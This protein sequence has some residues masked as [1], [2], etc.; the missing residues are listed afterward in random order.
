MAPKKP[1]SGPWARRK[2]GL[3]KP[4]ILRGN[5]STGVDLCWHPLPICLWDPSVWAAGDGQQASASLF[6]VR[7]RESRA[8][9]PLP[10][11]D[12]GFP[13]TGPLSPVLTQTP[14]SGP[15]PWQPRARKL[16]RR[17]A[18]CLWRWGLEL[19]HW[20][21]WCKPAFWAM[22]KTKENR[23]S[24]CLF[25]KSCRVRHVLARSDWMWD[26]RELQGC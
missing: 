7:P 17:S 25:I 13:D 11:A 4:Q 21:W 16:E 22:K 1:V 18:L 6:I 26:P 10:P 23:A 12:V 14:V 3:S 5:I 24:F 2:G 9:A 20:R 15:L 8:W 19:P